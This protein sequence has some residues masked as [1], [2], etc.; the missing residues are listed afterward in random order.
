MLN[1]IDGTD[2]QCDVTRTN[3]NQEICEMLQGKLLCLP[4]K[5]VNY[6]EIAVTIAFHLHVQ[7]PFVYYFSKT[8]ITA[9]IYHF[10]QLKHCYG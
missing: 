7:L 5:T 8:E 1:S 10:R 3:I 6:S 2:Q 4:A 9:K